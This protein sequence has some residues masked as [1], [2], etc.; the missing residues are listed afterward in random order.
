MNDAEVKLQVKVDSSSATSGMN[1][2]STN[3][4]TLESKF[5]SAGKA[6]GTAVVAGVAVATTAIVGLIKK[7]VEYNA[8]IEQLQTSFEVMTGDA[9]EAADLVAKLKEVGATTPYELTGLAE[10]TQML[11]QYG[12]TSEEAYNATLN[13]GDIS[14][15]SA[16]KMQS[17]ALA[18]GQ[19]S[20]AGKVNMQDI[21]QMINAGFNPLQA[22][23]EMTGETMAEVTARYE[24]GKI[25]VEEVTSA[26]KYASGVNGKYYQSM[27]KQSKTLNGQLSTLTDNF[28]SFAGVLAGD[29]TSSI[30]NEFLPALNDLLGQATTIFEEDGLEG[31]IEKLPDLLQPVLEQVIKMLGKALKTGVKVVSKLLPK[32]VKTF[33]EVIPEI[34]TGLMEAIPELTTAILNMLPSILQAVSDLAITVVMGLA[35]MLPT[36]IPTLI[37]AILQLIP[38]LLG[39]LPKFADAALSL[40]MGLIDGLINAIPVLIESLPTIINALI[41]G[42]MGALPKILSMAPK[43]IWALIKGLISAIPSLVKSIPQIL[44]AIYNGLKN[45]ISKIFDIG[46][47]MV[48]GLWNGIKS[49]ASWIYDKLEGFGKGVLNKMKSIFGINSPSKEFAIIGRYNVEGLEKGIENE[50]ASLYKSLDGTFGE[51]LD[52]VSNM[53]LSGGNVSNAVNTG[54]ATITVQIPSIELDGNKLTQAQMPY[55]TRTVKVAGGNI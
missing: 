30:T 54:F 7:G 14:Q 24:D 10:T 12:M 48:K 8:E 6:L 45:G 5:K 23:A 42:L 15:G 29:A 22:I 35:N 46:V 43:M 34:V 3:A 19:M 25:S 41:N 44:S 31:L 47:D 17:I 28:N 18:Y 55:I 53:G 20:S 52:Y 36:M 27:E 49:V 4:T 9:T 33:L 11:M 50:K 1:K 32:I 13:L 37:N 51:G 26:M 38:V 2:L 21:K 39:N 40:M 16:E